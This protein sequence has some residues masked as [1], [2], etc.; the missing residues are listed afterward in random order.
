[1]HTYPFH[2]GDYLKDTVHWS[3]DEAMVNAKAGLLRDLAYRRLLDLYY[4][5]EEPIPGKTRSVA[6]RIRMLAH[7]EIV[8]GVLKE[9]FRFIDGRWH[10]KRTDAEIERYKKKA[11]TARENGKKGGRPTGL[12]PSGNQSGSDPAPTRTRTR[13]KNHRDTPIP[14]EGVEA[15]ERFWSEHP[16]KVGKPKAE[17]AFAAALARGARAD[18]ILAGMRSHLPVWAIKKA[19]GE[20][21]LIPHPSTWLNRD[22]WND[23]VMPEGTRTGTL[24]ATGETQF[25]RSARERTHEL[26]GGL[27]SAKAPG[28]PQSK[29]TLDVAP[30]PFALG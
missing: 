7:E 25:E 4:G 1:M 28:T 17:K 14:P 9:K 24:G 3:E 10:Q 23:E 18:A 22:G 27:A 29:E 6:I 11:A 15:F 26:T 2:A 12:E 5:E 19:A 20:G 16:R 13:T 30:A 8:A 21:E